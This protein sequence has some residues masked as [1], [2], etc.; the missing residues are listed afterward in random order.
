MKES[1]KDMRTADE[2]IQSFVDSGFCHMPNIPNNRVF[3]TDTSASTLAWVEGNV[4]IE[5]YFLFPNKTTV[6]HSH[7]FENQ[8]I[9]I[10]GDMT[11]YLKFPDPIPLMTIVLTDEDVG[12]IGK[13]SPSNITHGFDIGPRGAVVYNIQRWPA[14]ITNPLS[15][16]IEY[17]GE[18]LGP[19]HA[20]MLKSL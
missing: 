11:A 2:I 17:R 9:F 13:I 15:A 4:V 6:M 8:V 10:S 19:I 1:T 16:T 7:P 3:Y 20:E 18:P 5:Y 12:V 14:D